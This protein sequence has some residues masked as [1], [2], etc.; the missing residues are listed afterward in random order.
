MLSESE[1][2]R[3]REVRRKY[4]RWRR[5]DPEDY[6]AVLTFADVVMADIRYKNDDMYARII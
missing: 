3:S 2:R 6:D 1:K 4:R 5:V